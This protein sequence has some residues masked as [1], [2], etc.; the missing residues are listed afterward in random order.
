VTSFKRCPPI[1]DRVVVAYYGETGPDAYIFDFCRLP[2]G[3]EARGARVREYERLLEALKGQGC[4]VCVW[5]IE[6]WQGY[7][8]AFYSGKFKRKNT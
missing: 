8:N 3:S 6:R 2:V 4:Q 7:R 1:D 5:E